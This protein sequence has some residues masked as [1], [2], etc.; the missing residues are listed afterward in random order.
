MNQIKELL[1]QMAEED[2]QKF[3]S[4]LI[5]NGEEML[6]V[7]LPKLRKLAK[8]IAKA[9]WR[10]Y[11]KSAEDTCFEEIML[12]G[13]VIG[14]AEAEIEERLSLIADFI[15]KIHNWSVCDSFCIGLKCA[16]QYP[17]EVWDFLQKYFSS[18]KE[19]ELRFA[20]VT[21]LDFFIDEQH[22]DELFL[23]LSSAYL[24]EYYAQMAAAWALSLCFVAFP[25]KTL[26]FLEQKSLDAF[27]YEKTL[28]KIIESRQ[29]SSEVKQMI[30]LMRR[31]D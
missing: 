1:L 22:I 28:T 15:P 26:H 18:H 9:D 20:I 16:K 4:A 30:R 25:D 21:A 24:K 14:Y 29:V 27:T 31:K 2:Y 13:M 6:G 3:S 17:K 19:F 5:P 8:S 12:Q 23:L 7:R 10:D 11:L